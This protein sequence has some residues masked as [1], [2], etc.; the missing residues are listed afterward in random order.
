MDIHNDWSKIRRHFSLSFKNSLHVSIASVDTE[1]N[2][3][4]TPI[5]SFFLNDNLSGFYFEKYAS[6]LPAHASTNSN[7]CI[8]G[9]NSNRW[10]W[11]K[12]LFKGR[13]DQYPAV[14]LYG[15]LGAKRK[16]SDQ[17]VLRLKRRMRTTKRLKGHKYLWGQMDNVREIS[18]HK[19]ECINL[20]EMTR[21]H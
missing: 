21:G 9:V 4:V 6:K 18:F 14:K 5:G 11:I 2:P 3:T 8:L 15:Q 12:S 7:I 16:A 19:A 13:F 20:A 17:E 10:L 1:Q